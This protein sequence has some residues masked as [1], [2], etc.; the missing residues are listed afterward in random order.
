MGWCWGRWWRFTTVA[1]H[2]FSDFGMHIPAN[3]VIVTVLCA[4]LCAAGRQRGGPDRR[5]RPTAS[6]T[7]RIDTS[8]G[9]EAWLRSLGPCRWRPSGSRSPAKAG[10]RIG[11]SNSGSW[12]FELDAS[13]DPAVRE[14]KV[15][16]LEAATRLVPGYARLQ[17]ELAHAHLTI[18]ER[19]MEELTESGPRDRRGRTRVDHGP[20]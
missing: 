15:A 16:A 12:R 18:L 7:T 6:P 2:S 10:G 9:S 17:A 20:G 5:P 14:Q 19:R 11:P 13:P 8:C 3:A 1:I 4:Q